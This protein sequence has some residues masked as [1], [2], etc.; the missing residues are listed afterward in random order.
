V[1]SFR[2]WVIKSIVSYWKCF[3]IIFVFF[4]LF[5][6]GD[7]FYR[8]DGFKY[9]ASFSEFLPTVALVFIIWSMLAVLATAIL[10]MLWK[11]G[12]WSFQRIGIEVK[13]S[14]ILIFLISFTFLSVLIWIVKEYVWNFRTTLNLKKMLVLFLV[15]ISI[16]LTW[17]FRY[18]TDH[19][20]KVIQER[21]TPLV[22]LFG[23]FFLFSVP[24]VAY[25]TLHKAEEKV[26]SQIT[27]RSPDSD[28]SRPN[29]L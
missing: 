18:K 25:T 17:L 1:S 23:M 15:F 13:I 3:R 9:Y 8:W 4:S 21:I 2:K 16:F 12:E 10:W 22:L 20:E 5:L 6:M 19:W 26:M 11:A 29:I 14:H 27:A 28:N 7:A 24:L